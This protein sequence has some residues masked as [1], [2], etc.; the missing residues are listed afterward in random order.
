MED[1]ISMIAIID[2]LQSVATRNWVD[3]KLY[4]LCPN[5]LQVMKFDI[6]GRYLAYINNR[7]EF[8]PRAKIIMIS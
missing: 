6:R 1:Y 3:S 8:I 7:G 5:T 4:I 2:V